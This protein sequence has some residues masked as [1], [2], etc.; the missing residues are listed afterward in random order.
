M[1]DNFADGCDD[2]DDFKDSVNLPDPSHHTISELKDILEDFEPSQ[3]L[4]R[5]LRRDERKGVKQ[6]ARGFERRLEMRKK[7]RRRWQ[8]RGRMADELR[9]EGYELICGL[10]EAGRGALAGPVA[11]AA[12]ILPEECRITG[13][14]DSKQL[15]P[16]KR[17]SLAA[18][19]RLKATAWQVELVGPDMIESRNILGATR[20]AMTEAVNKLDPPPDYLLIDG[21]IEL[22]A[23]AQPQRPVEKG[24]ASVNCI[25]AASIL[26]KVTRDSFMISLDRYLSGYNFA[27]NMGYGTSRHRR[28]LEKL[29]PST[30]HRISFGPVR[31]AAEAGLRQRRQKLPF[32]PQAG[33]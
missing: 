19:I 10:D 5:V 17:L 11:A 13:L 22:K 6:M 16:E 8:K 29:G 28:A 14:D 32:S 3:E 15:D 31:E 33:D 23:L 21:Q 27:G 9:R 18:E 2:T 4:C 20:L 25:A 1:T 12:V 7:R 30:M 24:D 26:A